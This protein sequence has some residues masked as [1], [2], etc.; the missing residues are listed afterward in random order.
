MDCLRSFVA[1]VELG[2]IAPAANFAGRTSPAISLQ[3]NRLQSQIG[4][5]LFEKQGRSQVLTSKG[6]EVLDHARAILSLNDAAIRVAKVNTISGR[7]RIGV[8]Q[9]IAESFFPS[10]LSTFADQFPD[11]KIE[12]LV[13]NSPLLLSKL[14][15]GALDQVIAYRQNTMLHS[16][17]LRTTRMIWLEKPGAKISLRRPLPLVLVEEPCAFRTY[18]LNALAEAGIPWDITLTSSSLACVAA[19]AEAGLGLAIRTPELLHRRRP[20]LIENND[21]PLLPSHQLRIY[22]N[23]D[24][25]P[26]VRKLAEYWTTQLVV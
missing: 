11:I 24:H 1:V 9:D 20:R 22:N 23:E 5:P 8:V 25:S 12:V 26:A 10:A 16:V 19:A 18:A 4:A 7:V 14:E 15:S 3:M 17:E 13:G 6:H 2:G 21:L